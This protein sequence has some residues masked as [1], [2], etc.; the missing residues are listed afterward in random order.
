MEQNSNQIVNM[1]WGFP[2]NGNPI[3]DKQYE[4]DNYR[5]TETKAKGNKC[6]IFFSGNGLYFPNDVETFNE[7]I[8]EKDRYEWENV[9]NF[10]KI[11]KSYKK[12]IFLRDIYKQWYLRGINA[13]VNTIDKVVDLLHE[14]TET[15]EVVTCGNSAGGYMALY[16]GAQLKASKIFSF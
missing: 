11:V 9:A 8:I 10:S 1:D 15:F 3:V 4:E 16:M 14:L 5:I 7:K 13:Q 12:I 2:W 6:I